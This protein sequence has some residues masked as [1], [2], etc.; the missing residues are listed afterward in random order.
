MQ[1][2]ETTNINLSINLAGILVEFYAP[3]CGHCKKLEPEYAQ[4]AKMLGEEDIKIPLVKVDATVE[5]KLGSDH[6]VNGYPTLK[7]FV[8]G[9]ANDYDGP[10]DAAGIVTW[11]KSTFCFFDDTVTR[12]YV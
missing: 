6:G 3:W 4:A 11:I 12:F 10:R 2:T 8:G 9:K 1:E 7:W 5:T